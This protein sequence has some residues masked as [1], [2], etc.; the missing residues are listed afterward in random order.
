M[1]P[2]A[3]RECRRHARVVLK[4]VR[5]EMGVTV[6]THGAVGQHGDTHEGRR[7]ARGAVAAALYEE[8]CYGEAKTAAAQA[9]VEGD[10][11]ACSLPSRGDA[12]VH[13]PWCVALRRFA[14]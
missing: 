10:M 4:C 6:H 14:G 11:L 3:S 5:L 1:L 7:G 13:A 2:L 9:C 8:W 12:S